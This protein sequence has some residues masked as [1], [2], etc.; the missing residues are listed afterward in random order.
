MAKGRR[1]ARCGHFLRLQVTAVVDCRDKDCELSIWH[2]KTCT[3]HIC[4]KNYGPDLEEDVQVVQD[5]C[6]PCTYAR[7]Q[8][9]GITT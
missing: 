7:Q 9:A 2:S 1:F 5:L 3:S 8:S 6:W 4:K